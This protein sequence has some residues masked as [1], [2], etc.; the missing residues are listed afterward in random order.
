MTAQSTVGG[1]NGTIVDASGAVISGATVEVV[2]GD[3]DRRTASTNDS[4]PTDPNLDPGIYNVSISAPGFTSS[5]VKDVKATVSFITSLN[6]ELK[7]GA[8]SEVVE[9]TGA[10]AQVQINTTDQ[11]LST[12]IDN[13]K[14]LE[15]PLLSR[16]PNGLILLSPGV[17]P[18]T[19]ALGGFS[20]N[21]SRERNNNF[22]V[23]GTDNNDTEVPGI[24]GGLTTPNIDAT[25]EFR[26]IT[27][28]FNAEFGRNTGAIINVVTKSGTNEYHGGLYY[29]NRSDTFSARD[30]FDTTGD[31]I[32]CT[33]I[34]SVVLSVVLSRRTRPSSL[35]TM[36]ETDSI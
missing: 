35:A 22:Q 19:S 27:N 12:L 21:G 31:H 10:D 13:K 36:K 11:Q 18:T 28:N 9:V 20:V 3:G 25:Q 4:E 5:T 16:D 1:L 24:P 30:F 2:N 26:V 17:V 6:L 29:Y 14:I 8:T 15:L 32:D 34:S 7:P 23:D 33:A